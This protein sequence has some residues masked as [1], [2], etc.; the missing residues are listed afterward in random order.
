[1]EDTTACRHHRDKSWPLD[2]LVLYPPRPEQA[3]P[4][5]R[6]RRNEHESGH[7]GL[8]W[9]VTTRQTLNSK[10]VAG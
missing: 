10:R 5:R 9:L 7:D 4:Q 3:Q 2:L 6:D 1:M 8:Y